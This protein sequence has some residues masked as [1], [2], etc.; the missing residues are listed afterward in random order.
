MQNP[1]LSIY[2]TFIVAFSGGKDS[3]AALLDLLDRGVPKS[4]IE[5][6]HHDVDGE[7]STL[8]DWPCTKG[9]CKAVAKAL[10]VKIYFSWKEGGF[11]REM[12]RD[13]ALTAPTI[14]ELPGGGVGSV[15]GVRGKPNTR[16][17]FPQVSA[18][19]SVRWC[20]SYLKIE[21]CNAAIRNQERFIGKKT[22]VVTGERAEESPGRAK[23][24]T[25]EP[26]KADLRNGRKKQRH[27]DHY[28]NVHGWE[29]Q[30]VWDII[31]RWAINP[32]PA[33]HLGWGRVSCAACIFGN[34]NQWASLAQINPDQVE[35]IAIY[36]E[37]FG[38]TINRTKSVLDL[39]AAGTP[40]TSMT[41][42]MIR[43]ALDRDY[44]EQIIIENWTLPAGA[45]GESSGPT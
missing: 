24:Q 28:R 37:G 31:E 16:L 36:E 10:G 38:V 44:K 27:V 22:L 30:K 21:I 20:S 29:E 41:P 13:N 6:W 14:F 17:K 19:L 7:D 26:D 15:G 3:L 23:Y 35:K 39:V 45:F 40:Y 43:I 1:D 9:Y 5:L 2:D 8:M 34:A 25:F 4:K 32:H 33:Y 42:D 18:D 12:K 11:E